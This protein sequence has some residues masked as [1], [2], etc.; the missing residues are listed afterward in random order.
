MSGYRWMSGILGLVSLIVTPTPARAEPPSAHVTVSVATVWTTPQSPRPVDGPALGNPVDIRRWVAG[1]TLADKQGL[2]AADVT[3]TQVLYGDRV[4]IVGEQG[5]W[6]QVLVPGQPSPKDPLGYPGWIPK[7]QLTTAPLPGGPVALVDRAATTG[8][9]TDPGLTTQELELSAG[10]R[11]PVLDRTG[12]AIKVATPDRGER[13]LDARAASV[14][15]ARAT[16]ADLV[17]FAGLLVNTP[18]LWGGRSGL[19]VDCSGLTSLVYQVHGITLPRDAGPQAT[20]GRPVAP[21]ALQPGDLMFY[22]QQ[23]HHVT[24]YYGDGRM[25]EAYDSGT[26]VRITPVRLDGDYW[27]ARRYLS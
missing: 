13:W 18:Y 25:I 11:L 15:G 2:S 26:P 22:G 10:T 12:T 20:G 14:A 8:L 5:D 17:R 21:D 19:G 4:L 27:G 9:F 3:Q 7:N 23:I 1:M 6:N 16:G 24:M